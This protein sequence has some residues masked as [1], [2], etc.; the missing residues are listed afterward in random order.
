MRNTG[1]AS[2]KKELV[3]TEEYKYFRDY[4][5]YQEER[6]KSSAVLVG[7]RNGTHILA[8]TIQVSATTPFRPSNSTSQHMIFRAGR[9][10]R[11]AIRS[12]FHS[13]DIRSTLN[14]LMEKTSAI[15]ETALEV[16]N[17]LRVRV[18][19]FRPV[20]RLRARG[21]CTPCC[22]AFLALMRRLITGQDTE[23]TTSWLRTYRRTQVQYTALITNLRSF[24]R[25]RKWTAPS[26]DS[27][28]LDFDDTS[29]HK[30]E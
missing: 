21:S 22:I 23:S 4:V 18:K 19:A 29:S 17:A 6:G 1:E 15:I 5:F 14:A 26:A 30:A 10:G 11:T 2:D 3:H 28:Y 12:F 9:R 13:G 27:G 20:T 16:Q 25:G 24:V 7:Q 8:S